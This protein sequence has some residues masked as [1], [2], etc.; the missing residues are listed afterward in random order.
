MRISEVR[1]YDET[2]YFRTLETL[3]GQPEDFQYSWQSTILDPD[4]DPYQPLTVHIPQSMSAEDA[5]R[6]LRI[7]ADEMEGTYRELAKAEHDLEN[8]TAYIKYMEDTT[9]SG[10]DDADNP[11]IAAGN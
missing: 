5:A 9:A 6:H 2:I 3:E 11:F 8:W 4:D 1:R 10:K 7:M